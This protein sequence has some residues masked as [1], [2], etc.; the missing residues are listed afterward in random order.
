MA[1]SRIAAI[2]LTTAAPDLLVAFYREAFGFERIG[3]PARLSSALSSI[4]GSTKNNARSTVLRLGMQHLQLV[5]FDKCGNAYPAD[6]LGNDLR[7]QHFAIVAA[8]MQNAYARLQR[9]SG[10]T[11][12]TYP[13]PQILPASSGGVSAF[14]FRDPDG[15]PL[16]LI[17]FPQEKTPSTWRQNRDGAVC[18]GI[19]HSAISVA[20]TARSVEFYRERLDFGVSGRSCNKGIEQ[21][22]LDGVQDAIVEVTAL[23]PRG[24]EPPH[25]ELLCYRNPVP[26]QT[27]HPVLASNDI[28]AT[29]LIIESGRAPTSAELIH[30]PDGHALVVLAADQLRLS[31]FRAFRQQHEG[32]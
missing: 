11:P 3:V 17:A 18:L 32:N 22:R 29:R 31:K 1:M 12:I 10:W 28:A 21:A 30:D 4:F 15:H 23:A 2:S 9:C 5:A 20:D 19:D 14:K 8:D 13:V 25:L 7:F 26:R 6:V 16:E 24:E 27:A